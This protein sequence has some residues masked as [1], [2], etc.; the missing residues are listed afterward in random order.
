MKKGF[1]LFLI[2]PLFGLSN[3][4]EVFG[5]VVYPLEKDS[6]SVEYA[7]KRVS[8]GLK[9]GFP[10]MAVVG[11]QYTLPFFNNHFA[12]YFDYSQY[13]YEDYNKEAKFRFSEWGISYFIKEK[14]KG[15]YVGVSHSNLSY[16]GNFMNITLKNGSRGSGNGEVDLR[17]TN[18][19]LGLKTGGIFYFRIEMGYGFGNLPKAVT[20]WATD[21]SDPNHTEL[22]SEDIPRI[23]GVSKSGMLVGNIGFG[24]AL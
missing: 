13:S 11:A 22:A 5:F 12:P 9:F 10:Y 7:I 19:R 8:G 21:N 4:K 17:T 14:G 2:V 24:I 16:N 6:L 18:L 20:F 1:L 15:L 3:N 23:N